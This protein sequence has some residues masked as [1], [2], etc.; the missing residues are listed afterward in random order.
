MVD[1]LIK[2]YNTLNNKARLKLI[3]TMMGDG[4]FFRH[5]VEFFDEGRIASGIASIHSDYQ[6]ISTEID[7]VQQTGS[8]SDDSK[9]RL[10]FLYRRQ[11]EILQVMAFQLKGS[12]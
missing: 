7:F 2:G 11:L 5:E 4:N 8:D 9:A 1:S 6:K 12:T 10:N 3:E